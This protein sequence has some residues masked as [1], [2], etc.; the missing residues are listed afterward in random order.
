MQVITKVPLKEAK[1]G[2]KSADLKPLK[3][4]QAGRKNGYQKVG[5]RP[6]G[7]KPDQ[8]KSELIIKTQ[9]ALKL[10]AEPVYSNVPAGLWGKPGAP[11]LKEKETVIKDVITGYQLR[12]QLSKIKVDSL[13]L[14][15]GAPKDQ[16]VHWNTLKYTRP[17]ITYLPCDQ[18]KPFTATIGQA[19]KRNHTLE[20]LKATGNFH[21][22]DHL[23]P[24][25][26][27]NETKAG[28]FWPVEPVI[29][30]LGDDTNRQTS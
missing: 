14:E 2:T 19:N 1:L 6:V 20:V 12:P 17:R 29:C 26:A 4:Q 21:G 22:L 24:E 16:Y 11:D 10:D 28:L 27:I 5:I 3:R 30:D 23:G 15:P 25:L 7:L 8:F 18:T 13:T 9:P